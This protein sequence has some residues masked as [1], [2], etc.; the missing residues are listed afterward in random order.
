MSHEWMIDVLVD[1][2][3][4]ALK[5]YYVGLAE[6]LDDAIVVAAVEL[7]A[8]ENIIDEIPETQSCAV[9]SL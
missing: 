7:R 4:Y 5:N 1:L 9:I 6:Q 3:Q 2:R 8:Q